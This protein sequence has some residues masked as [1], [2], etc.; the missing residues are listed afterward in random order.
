MNNR[1]VC[2]RCGKPRIIISTYEEKI[3]KSTVKYTITECSDPACQKIV[4]KG[5]EIEETKRKRIKE[6][7]EEREAV[8]KRKREE[9][10][11]LSDPIRI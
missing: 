10:K 8:K 3:E 7:Q 4:D 5:L 9:A 1:S 11:K 2:T 6:E